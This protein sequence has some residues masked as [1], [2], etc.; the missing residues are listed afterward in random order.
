MSNSYSFLRLIASKTPRSPQTFNLHIPCYVKPNSSAHRTGITKVGI[1]RV[2]LSVA[3]VPRDGAANIAVSHI[4][5]EIFKVPKSSVEVIR[6]AKSREK[7]LCVT[8]LQIGNDGEE[9]YL[10]RATQRLEAAVK[11]RDS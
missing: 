4:F 9:A 8:D 5:A 11:T 2:E 7:T 6:G 10:Q 3:A 1:D